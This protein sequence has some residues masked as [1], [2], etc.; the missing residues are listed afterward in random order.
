[1]HPSVEQNAAISVVGLSGSPCTAALQLEQPKGLCS[2][3]GHLWG[4]GR[5]H[6]SYTLVFQS[7]LRDFRH[8]SCKW[9]I[10]SGGFSSERAGNH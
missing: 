8:P 2:D 10:P 6:F 1:M 7:V 4:A 5:D 3:I 9:E